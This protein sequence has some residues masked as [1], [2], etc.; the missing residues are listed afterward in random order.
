VFQNRVL[1][2][3]AQALLR[4]DG[5]EVCWSSTIPLNDAG[6]SV[7]QLVEYARRQS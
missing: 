7:G 6:I 4:A 3:R 2:E 1:A 5:F